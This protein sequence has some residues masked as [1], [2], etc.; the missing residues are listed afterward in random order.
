MSPQ[1]RDTLADYVR[2]AYHYCDA[3]VSLDEADYGPAPPRCSRAE[4]ES[5]QVDW[6]IGRFLCLVVKWIFIWLATMNE[7]FRLLSAGQRFNGA[8]R[9]IT[10]CCGSLKCRAAPIVLSVS[11]GAP[12][13]D[14]ASRAKSLISEYFSGSGS[15][16]QLT[17][18]T[19]S[20]A[21]AHNWPHP[22]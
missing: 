20:R 8:G 4:G 7:P 11:I 3:F 12:S 22:H 1:N 15:S 13:L 17:M 5:R 6:L 2:A 18:V 19:S 9:L 21:K 16:T 14:A 10:G